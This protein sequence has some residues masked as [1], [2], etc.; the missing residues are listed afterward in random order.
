MKGKIN[1]EMEFE[2]QG[3]VKDN[4][5]IE[6]TTRVKII[7]D[8]ET[9]MNRELEEGETKIGIQNERE[10]N[11]WEILYKKVMKYIDALCDSIQ[12]LKKET[13]PE[14]DECRVSTAESYLGFIHQL[15][16]L[17]DLKERIGYFEEGL[18]EEFN[19]K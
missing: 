9:I 8:G 15:S 6:K 11:K 17:R 3:G 10:N 19:Q 14:I 7:K 5:E 18:E 12:E 16:V 1:T 4:F 13:F 2:I